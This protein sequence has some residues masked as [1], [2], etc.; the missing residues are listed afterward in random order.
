MYRLRLT[1]VLIIL[2][3]FSEDDERVKEIVISAEF[4][5]LEKG[6]KEALYD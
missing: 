6:L 5:A 4:Q 1:L 3:A 2:M